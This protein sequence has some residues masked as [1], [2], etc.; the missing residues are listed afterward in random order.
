MSSQESTNNASS[1]DTSVL[2]VED[3]FVSREINVSLLA[4]IGF[5]NVVTAADGFRAISV[6][7]EQQAKNQPV[8]LILCD[9]NMPNMSGMDLLQIIRKDELIRDIPF[10]LITSNHNKAHIIKAIKAGVTGYIVK[11]INKAEL[12]K[13][14]EQ[15]LQQSHQPRANSM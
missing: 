12:S 10:F 5:S 15:Y 11:P 4:D 6:L 3:D 2:V 14:L 7:K 8:A 1:N 13:K 9:W